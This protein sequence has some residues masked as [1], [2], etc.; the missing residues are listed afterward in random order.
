MLSDGL[1]ALLFG[2]GFGAWVYYKV[3]RTSGGHHQSSVTA[4][5]AA[6][7]GGFFVIFTLLKLVLHV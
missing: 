6:G 3:S 2:V 4:G 5:L 1:T 7:L